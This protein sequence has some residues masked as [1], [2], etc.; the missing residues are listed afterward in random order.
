MLAHLNI[1][2]DGS[3]RVT[4]PDPTSVAAVQIPMT[5]AQAKVEV[6]MEDRVVPVSGF[7]KAMVKSMTEAMVRKSYLTLKKN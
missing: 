1:D 5:P 7:T 4:D 3:N 6:L 2:S